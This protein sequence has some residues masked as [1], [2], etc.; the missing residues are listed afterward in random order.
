[1]RRLAL[2]FF[3]ILTVSCQLTETPAPRSWIR[4]N[5]LGYL[6]ESV[7]TIVFCSLDDKT[8]PAVFQLVDALTDEIVLESGAIDSCGA[9]GP[10]A[11]TYRF[12]LSGFNAPGKYYI[13][14]ENVQSPAFLI[15]ENVYDGAAD[16]LLRYLRQQRCGFNPYLND[17][18]HTRDGFIVYEPGREGEHIDVTGGWHDAT[19]YLQ[20]TAT[21]ANA[22][23]QLLLAYREAPGS[24]RDAYDADGLPGANGVPD[25][26]DEAKWGMDWLCRM[27]PAPDRF[28]NQIADDR[29]H[30]GFRLPTEDSVIYH[31][32]WEGRPVY[33]CSG[34][35]QGLRQYK[36]RTTGAA[37][38]AGKF[39]SAFAIGTEVLQPF[40]P[41]YAES[42][43]LRAQLAYA[44]G[45][46]YPGACQTASCVSPY[47]YEED[48]WADDMML[49]AAELYRLNGKKYFKTEVMKFAEMEPVSPWMGAD[50][51]RHY[52]WYPFFNAG[53]YEAASAQD[54]EE[55]NELI[56]LYREGLERI[57]TRG[58]DN[59]FRIGIPFIWCSNNFVTAALT[60]ISLY[61][62][63]SG[64]T[65]YDEM[66]AGLR[67]WLFGCNPW[68]TGMIV[69]FPPFADNPAD[70]HSSLSYLYDMKIDGGLVDGPVYGSIFNSLQG[71]RLLEEDEYAPFQS[72]LA[73]YHDDAGDYSTNEP[74][75]DGTACLITYLASLESG[76]PGT[77][78]TVDA[79]GA[80]IRGNPSKKQIALV[81]TAHDFAD[82]GNV[83]ADT[84]KAH[85]IRGSFFLTGDF[86]RNPEFKPVI[87]KLIANGNYMGAHSDKHLLY[88]QWDHARTLN[89]TE[90]EFKEDLRKNY[91]AM[92]QWG[93]A[94]E[95][96]HYFLPPYE[97]YDKHIALWSYHEGLSLVNMTP[98]TLSHTDYTTPDMGARYH[99]NNEI[100]QSV[101]LCEE[102]NTLNGFMLLIHL[103]SDDSR[104]EKFYSELDELIADLD[105]M[106][107][108]FVRI[109]ELL[110]MPY[111]LR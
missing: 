87:R 48:N 8:H 15:N 39:S 83:I 13:R 22:V 77:F 80:I 33:F 75:M 99:D 14:S 78:Q 43:E 66:E 23:F 53:H 98:G 69:G 76:K 73:V 25:V 11:A 70:P 92:A 105:R 38:T 37:S 101:M 95:D 10:F 50:T 34:E 5:Q 107:Y 35:V 29:D 81:F 84:L 19:D 54:F 16:F 103:G 94:R 58:K 51:A 1:M 90:R 65:R 32:T 67:D 93:I 21:S 59:P 18:C 63:L 42:L 72:D 3:V 4:V 24:F 55:S 85:N 49:A 61:Q 47:F 41:R 100:Y 60:Q 27:N 79:Q 110:D 44:Y 6:P 96:A 46:Q 26:I 40:Y 88:N 68:G 2:L 9:Y 30:A 31:E 102:Q 17:S 109:D 86:Y 74:T 52:Q 45:K 106:G 12:D 111:R 97:W 57:Y 89:I 71:L 108:E 7:K 36:N 28:F 82:G 56:S 104:P 64:D 62:K 20:Y 91:E